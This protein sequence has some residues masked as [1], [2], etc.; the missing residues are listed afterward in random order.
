MVISEEEKRRRKKEEERKKQLAEQEQRRQESKE[1]FQQEEEQRR[2]Q[3][4]NERNRGTIPEGVNVGGQTVTNISA[5]QVQG[6]L[7]RGVLP[8]NPTQTGQLT[9]QQPDEV[10]DERKER[11]ATFLESQG[12]FED[13]T[14]ALNI[15]DQIFNQS[16]AG[17]TSEAAQRNLPMPISVQLSRGFASMVSKLNESTPLNEEQINSLTPEEYRFVQTRTL[18]KE[19]ERLETERKD[20][21][22]QNLG[23]ILETIP[24]ISKAPFGIG[25]VVTALAPTPSERVSNLEQSISEIEGQVTTWGS[26][27]EGGIITPEQAL[28]NTRDLEIEM[29]NLEIRIKALANQ[30]AELRANPEKLIDIQRQIQTV[31]DE[32]FLTRQKAGGALINRVEPS[33]VSVA[34]KIEEYRQ[35]NNNNS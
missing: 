8:T 3:G 27:V 22:V 31:Y 16:L 33:D 14:Q 20:N 9:Q 7:Q 24:I 4:F 13:R 2:I 6:E 30:S 35:L 17:V 5:R 1:Q 29:L 25:E 19:L 15:A 18:R 11:L 26:E 23:K 28:K 21:L 12:I 32:I 10:N 34:L